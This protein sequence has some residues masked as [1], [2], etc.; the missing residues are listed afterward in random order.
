MAHSY[1]NTSD[2]GTTEF[3]NADAQ[4][5]QWEYDEDRGRFYVTY[6]YDQ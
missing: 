2:A 5:L 4:E 3:D 6:P 1:Y